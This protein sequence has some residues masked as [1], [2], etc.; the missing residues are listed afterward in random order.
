MLD[1]RLGKPGLKPLCWLAN[2]E[3]LAY[4][5][6][7]LLLIDEGGRTRVICRLP[8]GFPKTMLSRSR[9]A[10]RALRIE[11][12][13]ALA[14]G[15]VALVTWK[16]SVVL[17]DLE[18]SG[19]KCIHRPK[20]GFSNPLYFTSCREEGILAA[21]GDY[22]TNPNRDP[23]CIYGIKDSGNVITLHKFP[24][25]SVRHVHGI[26][27]RLTNGGG[28]YVLTGDM[29]RTSG[30]YTASSDFSS[31]EPLAIGEQRF[32]AVRGFSVE[33]GIVY[34]TDSASIEN[35]IYRL[36]EN[37][38]GS[39]R[40]LDDLGTINGPCI[41]GGCVKGGYLFTTTVEPDESL[42]GLASFASRSIGPGVLTPEA[43]A[44]FVSETG[45]VR[46][47]ARFAS[48]GMPLKALQYGALQVPSGIASNTS[49]WVYA[50]SLKGIDGKA[51]RV[52]TEEL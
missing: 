37:A 18:G 28:Y 42:R 25:G 26:I 52:E 38:D 13:A 50:R 12:R 24:S 33:N 6:G 40:C 20:D 4:F 9:I 11:P 35:H 39:F 29:E 51:I 17:V 8:L 14:I 34:A 21:W 47:V 30:I 27:P 46:E 19:Y 7:E 49:A 10:S 5:H 16:G 31:V 2:G 22:G 41:Y 45:D 1:V 36:R 32:R 23:V 43:T 3:L 44:V 15:N 48:D